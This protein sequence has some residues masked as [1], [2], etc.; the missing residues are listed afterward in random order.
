MMRLT[1]GSTK[2][3]MSQKIANATA[4]KPQY[5]A[6]LRVMSSV[7]KRAIHGIIAPTGWTYR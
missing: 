7:A 6:G 5:S 2:S 3:Q 1:L 4:R